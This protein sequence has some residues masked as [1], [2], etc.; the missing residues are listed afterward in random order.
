MA[1]NETHVIHQRITGLK[2]DPLGIDFFNWLKYSDLSDGSIRN[3]INFYKE[4]RK[5]PL[6]Q[7]S[8]DS[9][10]TRVKTPT[11]RS[12]INLYLQFLIE[13]DKIPQD[14]KG[15][16]VELKLKRRKGRVEER[17]IDIPTRK[18]VLSLLEYFKRTD[19]RLYLFSLLLYETGLRCSEGTGLLFSDIKFEQY[20][21]DFED[22][23]GDGREVHVPILIRGKGKS[24]RY[25]FINNKLG[26]ELKTFYDFERNKIQ[27]SLSGVVKAKYGGT[28]F[29]LYTK[30]VRRAFM[31]FSKG[32]YGTNDQGRAIKSLHPHMLRHFKATELIKKGW[33][34]YSVKEFLRHKSVKNTEIYLHGMNMLVKEKL[35]GDV[36]RLLSKS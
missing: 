25:V 33:D 17:E 31:N 10:V 6:N 11:R 34:I 20:E 16:I 28:L 27:D 23:K 7:N 21:Q 9:F 22:S 13:Y 19:R 8:I 32:Y 30:Q 3:N 14:K 35:Q 5:S 18:E 36:K 2:D 1:G 12:F 15:K 4:F 26:R 29:M 24:K